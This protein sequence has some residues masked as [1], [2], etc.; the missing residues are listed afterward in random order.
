MQIIYNPQEVNEIVL[1]Y[2]QDKLSLDDSN[3]FQVTVGEDGS[4]VVLVNEDSGNESSQKSSDSEKQPR[5]QKRARRTKAQIEADEAEAAA[6]AD[7]AKNSQAE[8]STQTGSAETA[9]AGGN[10]S[11]QGAEVKDTSSTSLG[12]EAV[13]A[14]GLKVATVEEASPELKAAVQADVVEEAKADP[15][16]EVQ[17]EPEPEVSQ[18]DVQA[19][20]PETKPAGVSLFAN[21][22]KPQNA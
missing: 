14:V 2:V 21:L 22:R 4:I 8:A 20:Q 3:D 11:E 10:A 15:Q 7:A 16:P 13:N 19:A 1:G 9:P 12:S 5:Q 6:A 17:V 18:E